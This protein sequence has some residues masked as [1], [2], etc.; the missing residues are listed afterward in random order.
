MNPSTILII[1]DESDIRAGIEDALSDQGYRV[2]QAGSARDA[3]Q[4]VR[5]HTIDL[6]LLDIW[7]PGEDGMSL[8]RDWQQEDVATFP[9]LMMSGHGTIETALEATK[10]GAWHFLEKPFSTDS[11]MLNVTRALESHRLRQQNA[12]LARD[13]AATMQLIGHSPAIR[14]LRDRLRSLSGGDDPLL[15]VGEPGCEFLALAR[16]LHYVSAR[17]HQPLVCGSG[18]NLSQRLLEKLPGAESCLLL[19]AHRGTLY[20]NP[21]DQLTLVAQKRLL[22]VLDNRHLLLGDGTATPVDVRLIAALWQEAKAALALGALDP[23]LH[24]RLAP[25]TLRLPPLRERTEDVPELVEHYLA[26]YCS[27]ADLPVRHFPP[28]VLDALR[29]YD[30]PGNVQELRRLVYRLLIAGDGREVGMAELHR[31][32]RPVHHV[33]APGSMDALLNLPYREA[34]MRFDQM[35]YQHQIEQSGGNMKRLADMTRIDRTYL[36]RKLRNIGIDIPRE[37]AGDGRPN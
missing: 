20:L 11:L 32:L 10:L 25:Q 8:L 13:S 1:D 21:L 7:M 33:P 2:L 9:I 3:R 36:Y 30:W 34:R 24:A 19:E 14:K 4:I 37:G 26:H 6:A 12:L 23:A 31:L 18:Q 17:H 29:D 28:P 16:H 5:D 27:Q 22:S 15:I 35:Y